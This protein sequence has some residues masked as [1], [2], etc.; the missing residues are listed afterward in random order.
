MLS[1]ALALVPLA[2]TPQDGSVRAALPE[3]AFVSLY[4][5]DAARVRGA[6]LESPWFRYFSEGPGRVYLE[7][8]EGV[9]QPLDGD[10]GS[11]RPLEALGGLLRAMEGE[12]LVGVGPEG[13]CAVLHGPVDEELD[14]LMGAAHDGWSR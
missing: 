13:L 14:A 8:V 5:P 2:A 12:A 10:P 7:L 4:T 3:P 6:F 11:A 1:L 9:V